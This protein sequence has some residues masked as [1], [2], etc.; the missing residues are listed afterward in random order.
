M[1]FVLEISPENKTKLLQSLKIDIS[2]IFKQVLLVTI[3]IGHIN[4]L[5]AIN[6]PSEQFKVLGNV[7]DGKLYSS[8]KI[9]CGVAQNVCSCQYY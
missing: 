2:S 9:C 1:A 7:L 6:C 4:F 8:A 5:V 3:N